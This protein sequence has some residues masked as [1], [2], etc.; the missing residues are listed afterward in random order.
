MRGAH[1]AQQ[2]KVAEYSRWIWFPLIF[3]VSLIFLVNIYIQLPQLIQVNKRYT[4]GIYF[5]RSSLCWRIFAI[6]ENNLN[7]LTSTSKSRRLPNRQVSPAQS[8]G[9]WD[10]KGVQPSHG[11]QKDGNGSY[12]IV[13]KNNKHWIHWACSKHHLSTQKV[14]KLIFLFPTAGI[15]RPFFWGMYFNMI[16]LLS[17]FGPWNKSFQPFFSY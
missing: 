15:W 12:N 10:C 16:L 14:W 5:W 3:H 13:K 7:S 1:N 17:H 11:I 2:Q 6:W 9:C 8:H 4:H